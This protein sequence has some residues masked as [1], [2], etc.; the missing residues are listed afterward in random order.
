MTSFSSR[1]SLVELA[2]LE[3]RQNPRLPNRDIGIENP[4]SL[5]RSETRRCHWLDLIAEIC[6]SSSSRRRGT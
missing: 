2:P 5:R 6:K 1:E 3:L 4:S